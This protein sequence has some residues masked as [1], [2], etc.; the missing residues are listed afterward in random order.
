MGLENN[1]ESGGS[2]IGPYLVLGSTLI[3]AGLSIDYVTIYNITHEVE[4]FSEI[5]ENVDS[6]KG[7]ALAMGTGFLAYGA[8]LIYKGLRAIKKA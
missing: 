8:N 6:F 2:W 4:K 7:I 5:I 1:L 3:G